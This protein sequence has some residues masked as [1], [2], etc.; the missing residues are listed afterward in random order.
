MVKTTNN[1]RS[2]TDIEEPDSRK[3]YAIK[4]N[5][6]KQ[7]QGIRSNKSIRKE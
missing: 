7:Y 3:N 2:T 5:T 4:R 1:S 6:K